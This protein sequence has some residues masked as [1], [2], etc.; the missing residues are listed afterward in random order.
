MPVD[1]NTSVPHS[2]RIYDFLL[3]GKDNFD[4]D[5]KAAAEIVKHSPSLPVSARANRDYL[6]RAGRFLA[7]DLG[8]RQFLDIGTG[9][10]TSPN[11]HEVVQ[12]VDPASR[13]VYVDNDPIVLVH[14][15]ALLTSSPEGST[16]YLD[17]DL[18]DA[19]AILDSAEIQALDF[20]RPIAI[21]LLAIL[22]FV[23]DE[24]EAYAI[25]DTLTERLVPGSALAISTVTA[26]NEQAVQGAKAYTARGIPAKPRTDDEVRALFRDLEIVEPG[27]T[28][29]NRWRP[30]GPVPDDFHV[31]MSGGVAVKR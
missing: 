7:E 19:Q 22:Q 31:Q 6:A 20:S 4:A 12:G 14:A 28:L 21:S 25:I 13:I 2:A 3:G 27:V 24:A 30:A 26:H 5:R 23:T 1:L 10:P 29:V 17:A 9:L 8:I 16:S 18:R 15:R 11:L